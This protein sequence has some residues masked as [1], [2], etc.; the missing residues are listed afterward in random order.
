M[1]KTIKY[2][3]TGNTVVQIWQPCQL[4]IILNVSIRLHGLKNMALARKIM[5]H[6][7]AKL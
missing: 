4:Y 7:Q 1:L 2:K 5:F 6:L 3:K